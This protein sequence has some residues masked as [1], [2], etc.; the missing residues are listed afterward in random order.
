M[1][2]KKE[3]EFEPKSYL[4][5]AVFENR[6][7]LDNEYQEMKFCDLEFLRERIRCN[8]GNFEINHVA[9]ITKVNH[10]VD[11]LMINSQDYK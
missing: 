10:P 2:L 5:R 3:L 1:L 6:N 11:L 4:D 9:V 7:E 8:F